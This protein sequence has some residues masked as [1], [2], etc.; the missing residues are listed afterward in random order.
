MKAIRSHYING[1]MLEMLQ[2]SET[3]FLVRKRKG[4]KFVFSKEFS[5][6]SQAEHYFAFIKQ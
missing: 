5:D 3:R 4:S 2:L 6:V 1:T